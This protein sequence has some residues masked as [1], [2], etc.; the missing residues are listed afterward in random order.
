MIKNPLLSQWYR[1][2][3][4]ETNCLS[5]PFFAIHADE[6]IVRS[7]ILSSQFS[8]TLKLGIEVYM[9]DSRL[10]FQSLTLHIVI[11]FLI[12]F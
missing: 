3:L 8:D 2:Y 9:P 7:S 11:L 12:I 5:V 1:P 6:K 4:R 10:I